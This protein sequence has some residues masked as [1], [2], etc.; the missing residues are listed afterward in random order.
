MKLTPLYIILIAALLF[1]DGAA[2]AQARPDRD[3]RD[4]TEAAAEVRRSVEAR[5]QRADAWAAT[6]RAP[7]RVRQADGRVVELRDVRDGRPLYVASL[8]QFAAAATGTDQLYPGHAL[9]LSLTGKGMTLGVWDAG[10]VLPGHQEF[11]GRVVTGDQAAD[12]DH[13]THVA[14]TLAASGVLPQVRGMAYEAALHSYDWN[15]DATEMMAEANKGLLVSNHSYGPLAGWHYGDVEETGERWYWFGNPLKSR[16]EDYQFGLYGHEAAEFDGVAFAHP[17]LLPVVAAGNDRND[18]GPSSGSYRAMDAFGNWQTY[19]VGNQAPRDGGLLGF[20]T[21]SGAATA[22]NVLTVGSVGYAEGAARISAFSSFG[23]TD[24][25]RVKPDLVGIGEAVYSTTAT[26]PK[27]NQNYEAYSGTSMAAP[28]IAG[29]LVLL[30]QYYEALW[31][32]YMRAATLKALA[33]HTAHDLGLPGPDYAYGWGLL[34]ARKAAEHLLATVG[35]G[36]ALIEGELPSG[37]AY[38]R[39]VVSGG[40]PLRVTLAWTDRPANARSVLNNR[41][42]HLRN[43]LDVRLVHT[44]TG[45]VYLPYVLDPLHPEAA[46]AP[47]DNRVDPVEQ[48]WIADAPAGAYTITVSS[49]EALVSDAPQPFSLLVSGA[50]SEEQAVSLAESSAEASVDRVLL[51]WRAHFERRA[52]DYLV[53]R[54]PITIDRQGK[55]SP[56]APVRVGSLPNTGNS[57]AGGAYTFTDKG[58]LAGAYR[59]RILYAAGGGAAG[60]VAEVETTVL[61]PEAFAALYNYPNPFSDQTRIVVDLPENRTVTLEVYD[62]LGRRV[63][64]VYRG[65]LAAGRHELPLDASGWASGFYLARLSSEKGV[66]T[67]RLVVAR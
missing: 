66:L 41:L 44:E 15:A 12:D 26:G 33:L 55:R 51:S 38:T 64:V 40:G 10:H 20:D 63:A 29:S 17:Y 27:R 48:I 37:G 3:R 39:T 53:E 4:R 67:Q 50:G 60:V 7:R 62:A 6:H 49:D 23:P 47:G 14:G 36:A 56:G 52:G 46:A 25:G 8:N 31:R 61:P 21:I 16:T 54:I 9:G 43:D 59:Y 42:S 22:K 19:E 32:R 13:A 35:N 5:R 65:L 34:D 18:R 28:N 2:W 58:L 45:A 57:G 24:D 1:P 30:Q 11:G